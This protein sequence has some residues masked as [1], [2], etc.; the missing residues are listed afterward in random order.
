MAVSLQAEARKEAT[1]SEIKQMR[2]KGKIPAVVYGEKVASTVITVDWKDVQTVLRTNPHAIIDLSIAS[3]GRQPVMINE[4]QRNP[5]SREVLHID[6][7]QINMNEPI[8]TVVALEFTGDAVGAREGGIVQVQ[9]HEVDIRC[10]P[11]QIPASIAVDISSLGLGDNLHVSQISVPAGVEMKSDSN[12]IV[13][14]ILVPQK[15]TATPEP[16]N[17][18]ERVGEAET[19]NEAATAGQPT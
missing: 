2:A 6:F 11:N 7:H 19:S 18:E 12:D 10:M 5:M 4:I 17:N 15:E 13:V 14:T 8:K 16:A 9:M 1:K 3:A